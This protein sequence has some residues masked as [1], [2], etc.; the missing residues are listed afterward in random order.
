MSLGSLRDLMTDELRDLYSA[1]HQLVRLLPQMARAAS[2]PTLRLALDGHL[3]QTVHQALRLER[4]MLRQL[5]LDPRGRRCRGMEGLLVEARDVLEQ[6]GVGA[7]CDAALVAVAQRIKHYEIAA[8]EAALR[9][10]LIL[11]RCDIA[12]FLHQSLEEERATERVLTE[13]AERDIDAVAARVENDPA[14]RAG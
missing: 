12:D 11:G 9:Y 13:L 3:N 5:G 6:T 7:V 2:A 4:I 8:Y 1:E 14:E 10:A